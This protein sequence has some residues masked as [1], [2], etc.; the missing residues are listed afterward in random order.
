MMGG[1]WPS[2]QGGR[3]TIGPSLAQSSRG[4]HL[5]NLRAKREAE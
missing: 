4:E 2:L 3:A 1:I 5:M